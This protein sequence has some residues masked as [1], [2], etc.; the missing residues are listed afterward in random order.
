MYTVS[1]II[2]ALLQ[3][4]YRELHNVG[5]TNGCTLTNLFFA[6][7]FMNMHAYGNVTPHVE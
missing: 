1:C 5:R 6:L 4:A 3:L 2:H 7:L